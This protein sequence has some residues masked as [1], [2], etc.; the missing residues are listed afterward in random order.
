M[1]IEEIIGSEEMTKVST[2][3][4]FTDE[5]GTT[6]LELY[7]GPEEA[8]VALYD[9]FVSD[10]SAGILLS[11]DYEFSGGVARVTAE[12]PT[13]EDGDY[14]TDE[15]NVVWNL[16]PQDVEKPLRSYDGA[17]TDTQAFNQDGD[18]KALEKVR[19][20]WERAED[21]TPAADPATTYQKHLFRGTTAY[22]RTGVILRKT[23]KVATGSDVTAAWSNVDRAQLLDDTGFNESGSNNKDL[24]GSITEMPEEDSTKKQ[25]F[26]RAPQLQPIGDNKYML[27]QDWWFARE[28][29]A[30][31]YDGNATP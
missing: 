23:L 13:D 11:C 29:S 20:A 27:T 12:Y 6:M 25:W 16:V 10:V 18:Q 1:A 17:I 5:N 31:L 2:K 8:G 21:Y 7:E 24:I 4:K 15:D 19:Q 14:T 3:K 26:K 30:N 9:G 22:I 28:W